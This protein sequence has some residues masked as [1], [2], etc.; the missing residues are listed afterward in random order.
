VPPRYILQAPLVNPGAQQEV[1][2]KTEY[3]DGVKSPS[4][5]SQ[6]HSQASHGSDGPIFQPFSRRPSVQSLTTGLTAEQYQAYQELEQAELLAEIRRL[7]VIVEEEREEKKLLRD[8]FAAELMAQQDAHQRDVKVLEDVVAK[9]V[10]ENHQLSDM[11]VKLSASASIEPGDKGAEMMQGLDAKSLASVSTSASEQELMRSKHSLLSVLKRQRVLA[12]DSNDVLTAS[13]GST[14]TKD[15]APK[16]PGMMSPGQDLSRAD[17]DV[18]K[19]MSE[20]PRSPTNK[21]YTFVD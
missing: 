18:I 7:E 17:A 8:T 1:S 20:Q 9:V 14:V 11:V 12:Y 2:P 13:N 15:K 6:A 3:S 21:L 10:E 19:H 16:P 4:Q 5:A